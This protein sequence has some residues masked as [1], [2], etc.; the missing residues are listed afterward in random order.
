MFENKKPQQDNPLGRTDQKRPFVEAP[1][2]LSVAHRA[3][4]ARR[5]DSGSWKFRFRIDRCQLHASPTYLLWS[6]GCIVMQH[7]KLCSRHFLMIVAFKQ[8]SWSLVNGFFLGICWW[9][10]LIIWWYNVLM[11]NLL[12]LNEAPCWS[13]SFRQAVHDKSLESGH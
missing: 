12:K 8:N 3:R 11:V 9:L 10:C 2:F 5:C 4:V 6:L 1:S 13:F 7:E